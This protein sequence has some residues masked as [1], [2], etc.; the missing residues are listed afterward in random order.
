[1]PKAVEDCVSALKKKGDV[2][3]PYAVCWASYKRTHKKVDG[4][5]VAKEAVVIDSAMTQPVE[6]DARRSLLMDVTEAKWDTAFINSLPDIA[7]AAIAEGGEKDDGS[8]TPKSLRKLP[9]HGEAVK[10]GHSNASVDLPHL[11]N[12]LARVSQVKGLTEAERERARRHLERH[13]KALKV[14]E[15]A[16]MDV[17]DQV[18]EAG[19]ESADDRISRMHADF[20]AATKELPW[21]AMPWPVD[22]FEDYVVARGPD[23]RYYQ[24]DAFENADGRFTFGEPVEVRK[25]YVRPEELSAAEE[26]LEAEAKATEE[27]STA[28]AEEPSEPTLADS[29]EELKAEVKRLTEMVD[30][31]VKH[32]STK[33]AR[34]PSRPTPMAEDLED[35]DEEW[36]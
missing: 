23:G 17:Y 21:D 1:M 7:F 18:D 31:V 15:F 4:T 22:Y 8:T 35:D 33:N 28:E 14:G 30:D 20:H 29:I 16:E 6:S 9:H 3:N 27:S 25:I 26:A 19:M 2:S 12:A 32:S 5:W 13:A 24:Y 36:R 34:K 11:R 10:E